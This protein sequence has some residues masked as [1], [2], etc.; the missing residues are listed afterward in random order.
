M[1][2]TKLRGVHSQ[3][4]CFHWQAAS[5]SDD[6]V[7]GCGMLSATTSPPLLALIGTSSVKSLMPVSALGTRGIAACDLRATVLARDDE[8][9]L[10][11]CSTDDVSTTGGG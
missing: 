9:C 6:V 1:L 5:K 10:I 2:Y 4:V 8:V 11:R 3:R 7:Q